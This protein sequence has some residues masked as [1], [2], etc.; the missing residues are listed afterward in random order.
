MYRPGQRRRQRARTSKP[1][2]LGSIHTIRVFFNAFKQQLSVSIFLE[3][4][5]I[6]NFGPKK[7]LPRSQH[8]LSTP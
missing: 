6:L 1:T 2:I 5:F 8:S 4:F 3:S 7:V